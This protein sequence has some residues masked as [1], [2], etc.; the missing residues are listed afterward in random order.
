MFIG[1]AQVHLYAR[2]ASSMGILAIRT[3]SP[4][5][6]SQ[7]SP[8]QYDRV[9]IGT[10]SQ[11][12]T[13]SGIYKPNPDQMQRLGNTLYTWVTPDSSL[14]KELLPPSEQSSYTEEDALINQYMKRSRIDG[15]FDGDTFVRTSSEPVGLILKDSITAED[16]RKFNSELAEK[17][18]GKEIDWREV[19]ND[20]VQIEV[21][22]DN[23]ERFEQKADYLASR[24]AVLKD[25]IQ[26][27]FTGDK[28]EAELQKLEQFYTEAK[29]K[30]A[31]SYAESIGG[32][33][34]S[35]GQSGAA[36]DMRSSVLALIDQK[37]NAY[38]DYIEKE[39][40]GVSIAD[41]DKQ[42]L[43]QDDA[44]LAAQ[45]R[46]N[47]SASSVDMQTYSA[48]EQ[49]PYDGNDLSF[50]GIY[51][52]SLYQQLQNPSWNIN[53]SDTA[54]G[55]YLASQYGSLTNGAEKASISEK[56]SNML[57]SAFE[58]FMDR[59]MD[60]LDALIDENRGWVAANPWMSSSIRTDYIDREIVY[61]AFQNFI[62][63]A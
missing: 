6:S 34:E 44:Y 59:L 16:L 14:Q 60:S 56:L 10:H 47:V 43:M 41:P 32:F 29:E 54:L 38:T 63:N 5:I 25:R 11:M 13:L 36:E 30:M 7:I 3:K 49:A 58:P 40:I 2:S 23:I 46:Q 4:F 35:L 39:G 26:S 62:S 22:F 50:A 61:K 53:D 15:Y 17:G 21:G 42:W 48:N 28:Q 27:Q 52:K 20:F 55:Q 19:K 37:A 57:T 24:Y 1:Q 45:L 12:D 9:E 33:Y 31:N 51:A 8:S 18:L